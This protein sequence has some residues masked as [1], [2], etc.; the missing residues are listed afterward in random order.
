MR[1]EDAEKIHL[2]TLKILEETGVLIEHDEIIELLLKSGARTGD[3]AGVV[4][5][6]REL[7]EE[8]LSRAPRSVN[9]DDRCG[10]DGQMTSSSP[11]IY[12]TNPGM[13][14]LDPGDQIREVTTT[15]LS[16]IARL[17]D[18]LNNVQGV[19]GMAVVDILPPHRDFVGVRVIAENCRRHVRALCFSPAG[20]EALK[21]MK[22]VL[23]GDWLSIGFTA[24][25]PLRWTFL[26]LDIFKKS[27][28]SGIPTTI[29]GEPMAGVTGPVTLAGSIVV[30]NAEIL[31]GFVVNQ[32]LE[33]GRPLIYNLG[34]AHIFDMKY[35]TAVTGA[36][37]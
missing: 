32:L 28:G 15:D 21:E 14:I 11:S 30:G 26:A 9:L 31:S 18:G 10:G 25:G 6:P 29:N 3:R 20:M 1:Q 7:V 4:R 17:C 12:W 34:L 36:P 22:Q 27:A 5:F 8:C 37:E 19:M 33:P 35:A 13:Q 24:H 2:A 23:P 16:R